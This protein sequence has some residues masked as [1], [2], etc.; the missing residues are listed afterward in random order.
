M[1]RWRDGNNKR[2]FWKRP[3]G[4]LGLRLI[5]SNL[6]LSEKTESFSVF[7]KNFL[8]VF[9]FCGISINQLALANKR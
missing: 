8:K 7:L 4:F 9:P 6:F 2:A 1:K 5:S 3:F